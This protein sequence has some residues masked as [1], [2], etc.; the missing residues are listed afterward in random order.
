[1]FKFLLRVALI[2][3]LALPLAWLTFPGTAFAALTTDCEIPNAVVCKVSDPAGFKAV[4]VVADV[5][6][7]IGEIQLVNK[8]LRRCQTTTTV[9]FD[10]NFQNFKIF[11]TK[12][13]NNSGFTFGHPGLEN[14]TPDL[15]TSTSVQ[16]A[17]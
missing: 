8:Q 3:L 6:G 12:C 9:S 13:D 2:L 5:G 15:Q 1:M 11:T 16:I 10:S 17:N 14:T 4:R 7:E